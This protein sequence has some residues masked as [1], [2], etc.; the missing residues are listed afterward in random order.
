MK[1]KNLLNKLGPGIITGASD[2]DPSGII[3]YIQA[4]VIMGMKSLWIALVTLPL[5]YG[6]QEMCARIGYVT[7][8]GL[9]KIIK[10]HFPKP[11]LFILVGVSVIVLTINIGADMLAIGI[12]LENLLGVNRLWW[13]PLIAATIIAVIT[14][15]SYH[16]F[17][18]VL[19][20][21]TLTLFFYV[22]AAFAVHM[23]WW[24]AIRHTLTPSLSFSKET[25]LLVAAI[26]GTTISPY[27]FFWQTSEE[28]EER[29]SETHAR[30]IHH[31][32][33]TKK[34]LSI[35]RKDTFL[36]ML[37]SNA[38]MWFILLTASGA[39]AVFGLTRVESFDEA[40]M[41]LAPLLGPIA[42]LIFSLGII[43]TGLLAIPVLAGSVGYMIAETFGWHEGLDKRYAKARGFYWAIAGAI[44]SGLVITYTGI[45]PI[46]LL[47]Y[48]AVLYALITPVLI[49][50]ILKVANDKKIM[51]QR[52]N[53]GGSNT[54]GIAALILSGV[55]TVSYV[56][57]TFLK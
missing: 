32:V 19:K 40:A 18:S 56:V 28:A 45:N 12:V 3:T 27:L 51:G 57:V 38:V 31:F 14:L 43:G 21:L 10:H 49:G 47:I 39:G 23:D 52:V 7:D 9:T 2:D 34:M 30:G 11:L 5:M 17:A 20:W 6:V 25:V 29:N 1:I 41:V 44:I 55:V 35:V 50:I 8:K 37:F 46:T 54:L 16:R 36:G 22:A 53:G 42:F 48:T 24:G 15:F 26:F 33:V 13:L 4:G